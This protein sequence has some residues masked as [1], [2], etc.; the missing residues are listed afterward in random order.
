MRLKVENPPSILAFKSENF[1]TFQLFYFFTFQTFTS[2]NTM[3]IIIWD[4]N[5]PHTQIEFLIA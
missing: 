4:P 5:P 1:L 2:C 3:V